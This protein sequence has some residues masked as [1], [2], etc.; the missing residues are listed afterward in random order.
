MGL[1]LTC[2]FVYL[3][4]CS[5]Q[6]SQKR[7]LNALNLGLEVTVSYHE[8][9]GAGVFFENSKCSYLLSPALILSTPASCQLC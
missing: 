9:A 4:A 1:L 7:A 5:A 3:C 6:E 8:S 2:M